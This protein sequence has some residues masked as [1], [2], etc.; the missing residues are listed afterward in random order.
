MTE[1]GGHANAGR[2][3]G[4]LHAAEALRYPELFRFRRM[5]LCDIACVPRYGVQ[6]QLVNVNE[7]SDAE[8]EN[9][10]HDALCIV[11]VLNGNK[12]EDL[13][14]LCKVFVG[15]PN[16]KVCKIT[17]LDRLGLDMRVNDSD[18]V[19]REYRVSFGGMVSNQFY[20]QPDVEARVLKRLPHS[21][22]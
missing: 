1:Q 15:D 16:P 13:R 8:A 9:L 4:G 3:G 7:F 2:F 11:K 22:S 6:S 21:L 19:N 12:T 18:V 5:I 20:D 14:H 10:A 17:A